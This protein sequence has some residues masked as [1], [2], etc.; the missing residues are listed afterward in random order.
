[1]TLPAG[2]CDPTQTRTPD[3]GPLA[4]WDRQ[5]WEAT[6]SPQGGEVSSESRTV[7]R[8]WPHWGLE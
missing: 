4:I 8:G 2:Y 6:L 3:C 7:P 5:S 1:M